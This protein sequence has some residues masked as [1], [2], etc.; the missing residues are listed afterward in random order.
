M[1]FRNCLDEAVANTTKSSHH[2]AG[3]MTLVVHS[4]DRGDDFFLTLTEGKIYAIGC[5]EEGT[6]MTVV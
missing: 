5:A 6:L 3:Y 4:K 2:N 1:I